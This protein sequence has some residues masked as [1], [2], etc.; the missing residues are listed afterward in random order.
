MG[1]CALVVLWTPIILVFNDR[2]DPFGDIDVVLVHGY[3]CWSS[4]V[5]VTDV[6]AVCASSDFKI[7]VPTRMGLSDQYSDL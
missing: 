7:P 5:Y 6:V 1:Q 3:G 2:L 4:C